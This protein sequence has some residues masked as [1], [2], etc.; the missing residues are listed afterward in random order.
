MKMNDEMRKGRLEI[1]SEIDTLTGRCNCATQK[2]YRECEVCQRLQQLGLKLENLVNK[3]T[4]EA[5]VDNI[6]FVKQK[7]WTDERLEQVKK[8]YLQYDVKTLAKRLGVTEKQLWGKLYHLGLKKTKNL[9]RYKFY[10]NDVFICE[11]TLTEISKIT[12]HHKTTIYK[13]SR[14]RNLRSGKRAELINES[15]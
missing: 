7:I 11:G 13:Y 15:K 2:D 14:E 8:E 10:E 12:G 4:G 1:L 6:E 5:E 9:S 3:K